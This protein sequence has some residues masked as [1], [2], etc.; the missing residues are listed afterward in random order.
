MLDE[1]L[2]K[3]VIE[4]KKYLCNQFH[5]KSENDPKKEFSQSIKEAIQYL[6]EGLDKARE[7]RNNA[8]H[9]GIIIKYKTVKEDKYYVYLLK[10]ADESRRKYKKLIFSILDLYNL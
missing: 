4:Y 2:C 9:G 10:E 5:W 7:R 1:E 6:C 3:D 8:S